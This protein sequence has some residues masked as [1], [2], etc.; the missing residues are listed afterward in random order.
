MKP[1]VSLLLLI[2]GLVGTV[3]I[4]QYCHGERTAPVSYDS[5]ITSIELVDPEHRTGLKAQSSSRAVVPSARA[6]SLLRRDCSLIVKTVSMAHG[7]PLSG[8]GITVYNASA[9]FDPELN[10]LT[11]QQGCAQFANI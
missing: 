2:G 6:S 9:S 7:K 4:M 5:S 1:S 8:I 3:L 10:G 11:D